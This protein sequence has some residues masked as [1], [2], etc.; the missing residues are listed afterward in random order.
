[1]TRPFQSWKSKDVLWFSFFYYDNNKPWSHIKNIYEPD[2]KNPHA[3]IF[4]SLNGCGKSCL[5]LEL[6]ESKYKKD[7]IASLLYTQH[8]AGIRNIM[9][10]VRSYMMKMFG[11][12]NQRT[13]Y[14]NVQII[15]HYDQQT[16]KQYLL[17]II[18]NESLH[19]WRQSLLELA[20]P[21][22][23]RNYY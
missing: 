13:S 22:G 4:T 23:H 21:G 18:Y 20:V 3:A 15:F 10:R 7:F 16:Q 5:V 11:L 2:M 19:K 12:S 8:S 6:I 17:S 14:I 9:I 1:M